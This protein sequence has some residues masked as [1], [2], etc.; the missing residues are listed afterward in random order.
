MSFLL[1]IIIAIGLSMD[2]FSLSLSYG[3][4]NITKNTI[5][6]ISTTVGLF[7]FIMPLLG[8]RLGIYLLKILP[9]NSDKLIGIIFI[10][11]IIELLLSIIKKEEI[12]PLKSII[13]VI[14]FSF[15]VSI[16]SFTTGIGI[17]ALKIPKLFIAIKAFMHICFN[18]LKHS[19]FN[20]LT[21]LKPF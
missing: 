11:L 19:S 2:S 6:K 13:E 15:A 1:T 18:E 14:L 16:D 7:H 21:T 4:F 20:F 8:N 10:I 9:I 17:D 12:K 3:M 5:L